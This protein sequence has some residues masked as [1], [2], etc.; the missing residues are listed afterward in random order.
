MKKNEA[1]EIFV[2]ADWQGMKAPM[3]MGTLAG[4]LIRGK[5]VFS[6]QYDAQWLRANRAL[7]LDPDL[8]L[9][10][11][12]QFLRDGKLSFGVF[13][14]SSPDRWGRVLMKRREAL[15]AR[16]EKRPERTLMESDFL[17]GVF[18][19][20]RMGA[21]RFKTSIDGAF[22]NNDMRHSAPPWTSLAEL[23]QASVHLERD[24]EKVSAR[25]IELLLAPGSSL[26]GARP[27]ASVLDKHKNLWIAKFPSRS[28]HEDK[29]LWE[30][31]TYKLA[32][33]C[34]VSMSESKVQAF[35]NQK[36]T[37]LT[38]RFDRTTEG[39]RI[40]FA[41]AMTLLGFC[42]G[43][44]TEDANYLQ[45]AEFIASQGASPD[46]DLEQLWRRIVFSICVKNTDDHLRNH[47]FLLTSQGWR[48]SPAYDLNPNPQG[49]GLTLN[50]TETDN[51]LDPELAMDVAPYFRINKERAHKIVVE[52]QREVTKWKALAK[53]LK[54]PPQ[55][56]DQMKRAFSL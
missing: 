37:F 23:A 28:D 49:T 46:Q 12:S 21:L 24:V 34:G 53:T 45:L 26:G 3:L 43:V 31:L 40:H 27:K 6:F 20:Y 47:G 25:W 38:K 18:D 4:D 41:S 1:K 14:D 51:A 19:E 5:E 7:V 9:Y 39:C 29:G 52:V 11:G 56:Q 16:A 48:L 44:G 10:E 22:Q 42:D 17:L 33:N 54:I 8:G 55:E 2:F 32:L 50:I 15:Q 35:A 13:A 36:H 30:L